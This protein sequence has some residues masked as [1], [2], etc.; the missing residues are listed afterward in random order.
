MKNM[1]IPV[2]FMQSVFGLTYCAQQY[3]Q[4]DAQSDGEESGEQQAQAAF[5]RVIF[6]ELFKSLLVVVIVHDYMSLYSD[7]ASKHGHSLLAKSRCPCIFAYGYI[8]R[9][10]VSSLIN[11]AFC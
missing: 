8:P 10:D 1:M 5:V 11:A 3:A 6:T 4:D 7:V 2:L 9:S